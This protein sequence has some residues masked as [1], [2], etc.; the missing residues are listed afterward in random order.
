[1]NIDRLQ[2]PVSQWVLWLE[3]LAALAV[4]MFLFLLVPLTQDFQD[5]VITTKEIR[6]IRY[7]P[8]PPDV[9]PPAPEPEVE[10][11]KPPAPDL[12]DP[13]SDLNLTELQVSLNPGVG[14]SL[15]VGIARPDFAEEQNLIED[16]KDIFRFSDLAQA[17]RS[18]YTPRFQF[19]R[20]LT[21]RRVKEGTVVLQILIDETG[22]ASVEKV[23]ST[24]HQALVETAR[25]VASKSRF[26]IPKINGR[27]VKVRGHWPLTLK[28]PKR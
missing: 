27:A 14:D 16:I 11:E 9:T 25:K 22:K 2:Q 8:P 13:P 6:S 19:P 17:P 20:S 3:Y 4:A 18:I 24:T 26:S 1:M 21:V 23:I 15:G 12:I 7:I 28:A 5:A 10:A